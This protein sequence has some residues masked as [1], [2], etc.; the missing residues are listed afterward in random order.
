MAPS[1][2]SEEFGSQRVGSWSEGVRRRLVKVDFDR[3]PHLPARLHD[4]R[5]LRWPISL[6]SNEV[7]DAL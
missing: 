4:E 7:Q 5:A 3:L 2:R 6:A 1:N